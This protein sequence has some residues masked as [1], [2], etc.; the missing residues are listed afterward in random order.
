[1]KVIVCGAGQV[2]TSIATHLSEEGYDVTIID[3][4]IERLRKVIDHAD[5]KGVEGLASF[6]EILQRAGVETAD[7]ILA[8]TLSDEVNMIVCQIAHSVFST[9]IKIARIRS[10]SYL[11][12]RIEN[13]YTPENL[14]IDYKISPEFEVSEA[15]SRSLQIP[16]A[17]DVA[18]F[19]EG[20]LK[21]IGLICDDECPIINVSI[22]NLVDLFPDL[23]IN[24]VAILRGSELIV[25]RDGNDMLAINDRVY[26]VC[27]SDHVGRAMAAFGHDERRANSIIIAG[28]GE[29]G[30]R[31][32]ENLVNNTQEINI[33]LIEKDKNRANN[34]A[35]IFSDISV[36]N[37][38]A[39]DPEILEEAGINNSETFVAVSNNDEVNILSSL[40]AKR[41]GALRAVT[42]VNLPGF[43]P[44]VNT[45]GINSVISPPQITVSSILSKIRSQS[46]TSIH[47]IIEDKGEVIEARVLETSSII[48][49]PLNKLKLPKT[50]SIG[51]IIRDELLIFPNG[52]TIIDVGDIIAVFSKRETVK[53]LESLLSIRMKLV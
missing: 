25:P 2:G 12:P 28:G 29:I 8:V 22:R 33:S 9:P 27:S 20:K 31:V 47:S 43:I 41:S 30:K 23:N 11:D 5:V 21:V 14:P 13:I 4:D 38:D 45:L 50:I 42:L 24:I 52:N 40:L 15:V 37:G 34:L 46:I 26:F 16:G 1:M 10:Q 32:V 17:F 3:H 6:P 7:I 49:K 18:N 44:L 48:G 19:G 53:K 39:L 36:I 51:A 35:E